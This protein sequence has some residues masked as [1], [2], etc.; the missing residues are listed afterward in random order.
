MEKNFIYMKKEKMSHVL[1]TGGAGYLGSVLVP[2]LLMANHDVTVID[3]FRYGQ[4]SLM[5]CCHHRKLSILNQDIRLNSEYHDW[6]K[7]ADVII[8]L[9]AMVGAPVCDKNRA[10]AFSVNTNAIEDLCRVTRPDQTILYPM[11]NSGYGTGGEAECTEESPLLPIS[12]YGKSKV[13]AEKAVLAHPRGVS[14]RFA[15]LFGCSP[16]MRL[17][18]LVNDFVHRAVRDR[19][20]ILFEP[21]FRR[22]FLHVRD[23]A[24]AFLFAINHQDQMAGQVYNVGLS[25]ANL[26]KSQLCEYISQHV[27]G[28]TWHIG[29]GKDPDQRNYV[30]S[31]AKIEALGWKPRYTLNDGI[32]ELLKGYAMPLENNYRNA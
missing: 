29:D 6:V 18:L 1:V 17:D 23:A 30:V 28:F 15:T 32:R 7:V 5:G 27:K 10:E 16:R 22:N 25:S 3:N 14:F 2:M 9:A 11:S 20:I 13:L 26:T 12:V 19:S 31:N 4:S 21:N 8:P 24:S